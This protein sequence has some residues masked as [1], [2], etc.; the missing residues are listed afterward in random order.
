MESKELKL[1]DSL[2]L[3]KNNHFEEVVVEAI[4]ML[5][6]DGDLTVMH[7]KYD[8]FIYSMALDKMEEILPP[9]VFIRVHKN[10][11]VNSLAVTGFE[12]NLL[13]VDGNNVPVSKSY[14]DRAF[15]LFKNNS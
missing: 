13:Y 15:E 1:K 11:M 8:E 9:S 2:F 4:H 12:G 5:K 10:Y 6:A 7:T 3:K 14:R